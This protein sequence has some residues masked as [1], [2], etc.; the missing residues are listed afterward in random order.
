MPQNLSIYTLPSSP[1]AEMVPSLGWT[2]L[3]KAPGGSCKAQSNYQLRPCRDVIG[4]V[5]RSSR[6]GRSAS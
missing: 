5:F 3:R 6:P 2:R 1:P 4:R